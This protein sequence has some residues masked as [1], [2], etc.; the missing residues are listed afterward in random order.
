MNRVVVKLGGHALDSLEP[1]SE[2]LRDLA[3]DVVALRSAGTDVVIVHGGGPQIGA[4]L[5]STG[6]ESRFHLGLRI[7]NDVTMSYVAMALSEVNIRIVA[8]LNAAGLPA[9]GLSG[10]D[11]STLESSSLGEPWLRAGSTP[12][13]RG[14]LIES[15]WAQMLTPVM[16]SVAVDPEGRLLNC[17]ADAAAGALAA[18]LGVSVL[19][20]LS[21]VD[22]LRTDPDDT[23]SAVASATREEVREL[24]DSGAARDGMRPKMVA[25]LDA[26]DGGAVRILMA[27]G[28]RRHALRDALNASIPTTEVVR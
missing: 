9:V 10:A 5:A 19:V 12:K 26:L 7:T 25:A 18:A 16:T 11:A 6:V 27:N 15:L 23:L 22:Q 17:N 13:V 8:A 1:T 4:L 2:V 3:S 28:T 20:L 24:V 21:D 14:G